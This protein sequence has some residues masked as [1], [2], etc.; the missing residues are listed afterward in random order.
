VADDFNGNA[1]EG[2]AIAYRLL[3]PTYNPDG[4]VQMT[5]EQKIE[6]LASLP[7]DQLEATLDQA[8]TYLQLEN[9]ISDKYRAAYAA[10][11][12]RVS[13][14]PPPFQAPSGGASPPASLDRLAS[15]SENAADYIR[16][17]RQ[18]LKAENE[19]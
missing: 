19:R 5:A 4:T 15:K 12:R 18:Q 13:K 9:S 3:T 14:A 10:A 17:R 1:N 16:L 2:M 11:P 6:Y 8:G 7:P